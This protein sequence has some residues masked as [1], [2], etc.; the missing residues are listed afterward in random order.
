MKIIRD[1][2][3]VSYVLNGEFDNY[4]V[5]QVKE[6]CRYDIEMTHPKIVRLNFKQVTFIDS[7]GLGFVLARYKQVHAYGGELRLVDVPDAVRKVFMLSG[8]FTIMKQE[9]TK[10]K[11]L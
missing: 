3:G 2:S 9:N 1:K 7:T 6:L 11:V 5:Q 8:V 10:E 4:H